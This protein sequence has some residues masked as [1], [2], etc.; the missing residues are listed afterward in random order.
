MIIG[1]YHHALPKLVLMMNVANSGE[2]NYDDDDEV[3]NKVDYIV[4]QSR[5][6]LMFGML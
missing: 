6:N 4:D 2:E 5:L 1:I 3:D